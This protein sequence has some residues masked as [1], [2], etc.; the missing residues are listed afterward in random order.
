MSFAP[1]QAYHDSEGYQLA[2]FGVRIPGVSGRAVDPA[3][4]ADHGAPEGQP[5][6][7]RPQQVDQ[8][9][10]QLRSFLL[11]GR[12]GGGRPLHDGPWRGLS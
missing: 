3:L 10:R 8:G 5:Y 7:D 9:E 11:P 12:R 6:L 4:H 2:I 1:N